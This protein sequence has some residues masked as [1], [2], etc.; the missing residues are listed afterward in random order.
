MTAVDAAVKKELRKAKR[1]SPKAPS[2]EPGREPIRILHR[3]VEVR[4]L[5]QQLEAAPELWDENVFRTEGRGP[6]AGN[7]HARISDII[8]RFNDWAN[9]TGDRA[10]FNAEHE[11]VWWGPY[12]KLPYLQPLVF[13]LMRMFFAERL[14]MVLITRIPPHCNVER[15]VDA[16]WHAQHYLK[17][18]IQV[19][20][21]AGQFFCYDGCRVETK[22][23]DL[24]AFDNSRPHWVENDTDE[25]RITLIVCLR[26]Q[27]SLC[28]DYRYAGKV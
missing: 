20:A 7:P 13:D 1:P 16:G 6:Y 24:F 17:F 2:Y 23:G 14:G 3:G 5:V 28:Y 22:T 15:H 26:L 4:P 19:K 27:G 21:A 8:C 18:G 12:D 11:S 10:A 9:W 25:E